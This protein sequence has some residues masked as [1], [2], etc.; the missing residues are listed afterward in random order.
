MKSFH[1]RITSLS[2]DGNDYAEFLFGKK[3]TRRG[4]KKY[5]D[6]AAASALEYFVAHQE[7]F[8]HFGHENGDVW[9]GDL[10][11]RLA[12]EME[13]L[14]FMPVEYAA[15][16][17]GFWYSPIWNVQKIPEHVKKRAAEASKALAEKMEAVLGLENAADA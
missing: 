3:L 12:K 10:Y 6:K 8:Q 9:F 4:F 15:S 2:E 14:G 13:L 16:C 17:E 11:G 1:Y 5:V 7:E